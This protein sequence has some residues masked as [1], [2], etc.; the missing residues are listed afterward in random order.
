MQK[1]ADDDYGTTCKLNK[2]TQGVGNINLQ[3]SHCLFQEDM[4]LGEIIV[5]ATK[6]EKKSAKMMKNEFVL[7]YMRAGR[8][9]VLREFKTNNGTNQAGTI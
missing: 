2:D 5:T 7:I 4:R 9:R 8:E 1:Q 6:E 3:I